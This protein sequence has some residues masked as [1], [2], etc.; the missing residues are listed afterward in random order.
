MYSRVTGVSDGMTGFERW[1]MESSDALM[2]RYISWG[3]LDGKEYI[4]FTGFFTY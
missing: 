3:G 4:I 2:E 1:V